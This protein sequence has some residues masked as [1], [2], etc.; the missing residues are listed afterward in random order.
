[1]TEK[2][3]LAIMGGGPAGY[4]AAIRAG[5]LGFRVALI[6]E[7]AIGGVCL[8]RGCIP[9]KAILA[10]TEGLLW[11][12]RAAKAGVIDR[13][14]G[15]NFAA[16]MERK[17][18][19]VKG[20]V[21]NLSDYIASLGVDIFPAR[22][23]A[24]APDELS[25][26]SGEIIKAKSIFISTGSK[27]IIPPIP[28]ADS[29]L[30]MNSRKILDL[31]KVPPRLAI[32]GGGI[33]GQEFGAMFAALGSQVT[34]FEALDSVLPGVDRDIA[35]RYATLARGRGIKAITS[36]F[37]RSIS[38]TTTGV[39]LVYEKNGEEKSDEADL[40][41]VAAGRGPN[42]QESALGRLEL[43]RNGSAIA[44][45]DHLRTNVEGVYAGGDVTG[46]QMLAHVASFH[47]EHVAL[48]LREPQAPLNDSLAPCCVFTQPQIAWVG[49][50]EEALQEMG[51]PYRTSVFSLTAGGKAQAMGEPR[52]W[53]KL[54]EDEASGKLLSAIFL[55]PHVS[56]LISE[57]TLAINNGFTARDIADAMHPHPTISESVREAALGFLEGPIH[58]AARIKS[59][60]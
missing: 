59:Y 12:Q 38:E 3:D 55:G 19:V 18:A 25:L 5:G 46:G 33:I 52:G 56:E 36:A 21:G 45:D 54:I 24:M 50:S 34:I 16:V 1:M 2:Y 35:K 20:L 37:V 44:V 57:M 40:I 13:A 7:E 17:R 47:G 41:L 10:D 51:K 58:S 23:E 28:G 43:R 22:A 42:C 53:L 8:N 4:S 27:S 30:V 32:I 31:D 9:T 26:S 6:E 39:R 29:E 15:F 60:P 11:N 48:S 49:P 14:P